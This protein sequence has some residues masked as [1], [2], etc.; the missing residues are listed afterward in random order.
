M[1]RARESRATAPK[2]RAELIR[3]RLREL[4]YAQATRTVKI[5]LR[6]RMAKEFG[7]DEANVRG[8]LKHKSNRRGPRKPRCCR[9][10][11]SGY[12]PQKETH[13]G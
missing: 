3:E 12:E 5:A 6:W 4:G 10:Q 9:C 13:G 1:S 11:G 2:S 8:A 7:C